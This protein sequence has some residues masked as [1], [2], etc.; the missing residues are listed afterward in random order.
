MWR[1]WER[2]LRYVP[3]LRGSHSELD[4][5]IK[6]G[7]SVLGVLIVEDTRVDAFGT[8]DFAVLQAVA[9]QLA[10][11]LENARLFEQARRRAE[12]QITITEMIR[13]LNV[14][15]DVHQAFPALVKGLRSD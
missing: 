6:T 13:A 8:D 3:G 1:Y 10:V 5:P 15:L 2:Q 11:A 12:E 9:N 4:V 7:A 14:A